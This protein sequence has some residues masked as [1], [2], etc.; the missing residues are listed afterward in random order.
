MAT[1]KGPKKIP[2]L[3]ALAANNIAGGDLFIVEDVSAGNTKSANATVLIQFFGNNI[4]L[5]GPYVNDAAAN[6]AG[7]AVGTL[8]YT[9]DG[10]AKVRLA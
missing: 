10:T 7:V 5:R 9:T 3:S 8:Y 1:R 2:E 6:T 4:A